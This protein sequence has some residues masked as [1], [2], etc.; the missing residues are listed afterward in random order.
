MLNSIF[1]LARS[2]LEPDL[3][4]SLITT[5]GNLF[6]WNLAHS[7]I[8]ILASAERLSLWWTWLS[9]LSERRGWKPSASEANFILLH[10]LKY[11][12]T[13]GWPP[14]IMT[15][16]KSKQRGRTGYLLYLDGRLR[17][18]EKSLAPLLT[19]AKRLNACLELHSQAVV[20]I[21]N[22][23]KSTGPKLDLEQ[24]RQSEKATGRQASPAPENGSPPGP[25]ERVA[26]A[27]LCQHVAHGWQ[28]KY[29][30]KAPYPLPWPR[31][32]RANSEVD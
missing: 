18:E 22:R 8:W 27:S 31:L 29:S 9:L 7:C 30:S 19:N 14:G 12:R 2:R 10:W 6:L 11:R 28:R 1:C 23:L 3:E 21:N 16:R 32:M 4:Y 5:T 13:F 20:W 26:S 17:R 15:G 25:W 24:R